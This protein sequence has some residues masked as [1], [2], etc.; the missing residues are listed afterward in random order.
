MNFGNASDWVVITVAQVGP[1]ELFI[2][3]Q[4]D[5]ASSGGIARWALWGVAI[6]LL[7]IAA[8]WIKGMSQQRVDPRELAFRSLSRKI[9]L[10]SKQTSAIRAIAQRDG[11]HPVGLLMS[12]SAVRASLPE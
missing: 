12:P 9:G 8:V 11:V 3:N 1:T 10:S 6:A 4:I 5:A 2:P 7:V